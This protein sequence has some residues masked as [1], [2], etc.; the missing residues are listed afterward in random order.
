MGLGLTTLMSVEALVAYFEEDLHA[1]YGQGMVWVGKLAERLNLGMDVTKEDFAA[2]FDN[3]RP[4]GE[5]L[6]ARNNKEKAKSLKW[7]WDEAQKTCVKVERYKSNRRIGN[8]IT[9]TAKKGE[10]L[11]AV[12]D[13]F[14]VENVLMPSLEETVQEIERDAVQVRV[15]KGGVHKTRATDEWLAARAIHD[16]S[17]PT[18]GFPPDPNWHAHLAQAN[19]SW[20]AVEKKLK[21]A[22][23]GVLFDR[24]AYYQARWHARCAEK[25]LALNYG[26][27]READ[28][29]HLSVVGND[30]ERMYSKRTAE[31]E[32]E[33]KRRR[34][35]LERKAS[36]IVTA[37]AMNGKF[38]EQKA[39]YLKL[40]AHIGQEIRQGKD[41][42]VLE[43]EARVDAWKQEAGA[44]VLEN[45][46]ENARNGQRI[47]FLDKEAAQSLA[48][49]HAF[50]NDC[51]IKNEDLWISI[52]IFGAGTMTVAE[53]DRFVESDARLVRNPERPGLVTTWDIVREEQAIRALVKAGEGMYQGLLES[54]TDKSGKLDIGQVEAVKGALQSK[55]VVF[56]VPGAPGSGKSLTVATLA[57]ALKKEGHEVI[58]LAPTGRSRDAL[59]KDSGTGSAYT[60]AKFR[61]SEE[62]QQKATGR[63]IF[64]DEFSLIPNADEKWLLEFAAANHKQ[65]I[66]FGDAAQYTGVSRGNP[67]NDLVEAGRLKFA[68]LTN[69][70]R[71][72]KNPELK[73]LA[74]DIVDGRYKESIERCKKNKWIDIQ[75]SEDEC[76]HAIVDAMIAEKVAGKGVLT[77]A[78][79]HRQG[80]EICHELR[81]K[82]KADGL[83]GL[84]DVEVKTLRD[85]QITDA[86]L[87]DPVSH[88]EGYTYKFHRRASGGFQ[89]GE[90]WEYRRVENGRVIAG[91]NGTEKVL[92]LDAVDSFRAYATKS[93]TIAE[94]DQL[95]ATRND[96][97]L[98]VSTGDMVTVQKLEGKWATLSNGK[99]ADLAK[100]IHFRQGWTVTGYA[101][102]GDQKYASFLYMPASASRHFNQRQWRVGPTRAQEKFR[103]F[104]DSLPL[105]EAGIVRPVEPES[106]LGLLEPV[107]KGEPKKIIDQKVQADLQ[108]LARKRSKKLQQFC[109]DKAKKPEQGIKR[110]GYEHSR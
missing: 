91:R 73:A 81:C 18:P 57:Q 23:M 26:Y 104:T 3:R 105:V 32:S 69:I 31:I 92:P 20:D 84:E 24:R 15:R 100:G 4:S 67:V 107:L 50:Q 10:S 29:L 65:L 80:E 45:I 86:Q 8:D 40:K 25:G 93:M 96:P 5:R 2:I 61:A 99:K 68:E 11:L 103:V 39:V 52:S 21:A 63:Y 27:R 38:L 22:E 101:S 85:V 1:Y 35:T 54:W 13:K 106:A 60:I 71:Q 102:Q 44:G 46:W 108:E 36:A 77:T 7:E 43:G 58:V 94:G 14:F 37:A 89:S 74:Q 64:T 17:R 56:A 87:A 83:L 53:M 75:K 48:I 90:E 66:Q 41:K 34:H 82:L 95:L 70:Y 59:A 16:V 47:G 9:F 19:V 33:E 30:L 72:K 110:D 78:Y 98:G 97:L 55:D 51:V 79:E 6:T 42:I 62:L 76:R 49:E 28:G 12:K 88:R 109:I